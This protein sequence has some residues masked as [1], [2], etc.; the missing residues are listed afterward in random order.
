MALF[1]AALLGAVLYISIAAETYISNVKRERFHYEMGV[2]NDI[3]SHDGSST[4]ISAQLLTAH[5]YSDRRRYKL[6]TRN[7]YSSQWWQPNSGVCVS[8]FTPRC[9]CFGYFSVDRCSRFRRW[10]FNILFLFRRRRNIQRIL[11]TDKRRHFLLLFSCYQ[12][13]KWQSIVLFYL[14]YYFCCWISLNKSDDFFC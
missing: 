9:W 8:L 13:W 11:I 5:V 6:R 7:N 4:W 14:K 3:R 2:A 10:C 12:K 1:F